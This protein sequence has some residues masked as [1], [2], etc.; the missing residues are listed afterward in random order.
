VL[1]GDEDQIVPFA[2]SASL[3]AKLIKNA[4]LVVYQGA[5]LGMCTTLKDRVNQELLAFIQS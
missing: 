1:H 2:D 4:K 5:P 3:S